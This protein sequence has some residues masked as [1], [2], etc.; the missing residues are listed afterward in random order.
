M[1]NKLLVFFL[2]LIGQPLFAKMEFLPADVMGRAAE[3]Q[4]EI[5]KIAPWA[6]SNNLT[7]LT[8]QNALV[9]QLNAAFPNFPELAE[10][11]PGPFTFSIYKRNETTISTPAPDAGLFAAIAQSFA[12][13]D[14]LEEIERTFERGDQEAI[15]KLLRHKLVKHIEDG[16]DLAQG[17]LIGIANS[18]QEDVRTKIFQAGGPAHQLD[19]L[20]NSEVDEKKLV[21][22]FNPTR[23]RVAHIPVTLTAL[24]HAIEKS[25]SLQVDFLAD[26]ILLAAFLQDDATSATLQQVQSDLVV[27]N[28]R[29]FGFLASDSDLHFRRILENLQTEELNRKANLIR[30]N[31]EADHFQVVTREVDS[32]EKAMTIYEVQ[33]Y[34]GI[35]RGCLGGDCATNASWAFSYSPYEH[36]FY[37]YIGNKPTGYIS[38]TRLETEMGPTLYVKDIVGKLLS[39][40]M[41]E[42][43]VNVLPQIADFYGVKGISLAHSNFT[44]A[45]NKY[46]EINQ[47]L[48]RYDD[49]REDFSDEDLL[50][51]QF[52][53]N[54][55][56]EMIVNKTGVQSKYD[57]PWVHQLSV[58]FRVN[59]EIA[60]GLKLEVRDGTLEMF[61]PASDKEALLM[62]L[63]QLSIDPSSNIEHLQ[64]INMAEALYIFEQLKNPK[65][66][67][68]EPYYAMIATLFEPFG[69]E[70]SKNFI[71]THQE[72]FWQGHLQASNAFGNLVDGLV[73]DD[74]I[75]YLIAVL[76]RGY[77]I[78]WL[79]KVVAKWN[80]EI[81]DIDSFRDLMGTM[82]Q[83]RSDRDF[84]II[85][86]LRSYNS[87]LA[88]EAF[89]SEEFRERRELLLL[90]MIQK[91]VG[92]EY[93]S[94]FFESVKDSLAVASTEGKGLG[95]K[96]MATALADLREKFGLED[97]INNLDLQDWF[98]RHTVYVTTRIHKVDEIRSVLQAVAKYNH[99]S[100]ESL[101][102]FV[103]INQVWQYPEIGQS[104]NAIFEKNLE[105]KDLFFAHLA[106][107][108]AG[109]LESLK[110]IVEHNHIII[111]ML[112]NYFRATQSRPTHQ[113][114][115]AI[116][117]FGNHVRG[118]LT[119]VWNTLNSYYDGEES[120]VLRTLGL[121][122]T[123]LSSVPSVA[124][125]IIKQRF[126]SGNI[127]TTD[128][129]QN[130]SYADFFYKYMVKL[131]DEYNS[132]SLYLVSRALEDSLV[133]DNNLPYR[134]EL[135]EKYRRRLASLVKEE[136][137]W[138]LNSVNVL[139]AKSLY[140]PDDFV[141]SPS[142]ISRCLA[143]ATVVWPKPREERWHYGNRID[144][145]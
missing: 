71:N 32:S 80:A 37:I 73:P 104:Y 91:G 72:F 39:P 22:K 38:A 131:I 110:Y 58:R 126:L 3:I 31:L 74:T 69:I 145:N 35:H 11:K 49:R 13:R 63:G 78:E 111:E 103:L 46:L 29:L 133:N 19:V 60:N 18:Q 41:V 128:L 114:F 102:D 28:P 94:Q 44:A 81:H 129:N 99:V 96:K 62:A 55:I 7:Y 92:P 30:K 144:S 10:A 27:N 15:L 2:I 122:Y 142:L 85:T 141:L 57:S 40:H 64:G 137:P 14:V 101:M 4:A 53:D 83:R 134:N 67:K 36:V 97:R 118:E 8:Q 9:N 12:K 119:Q 65:A 95:Y 77:D 24:I 75:R 50:H 70:L 47:A 26:L 117:P 84:A 59:A 56:R 107:H 33:P 93:T 6:R 143:T 79:G 61:S 100:M 112:D 21:E 88:I 115:V 17:I 113:D 116:P 54:D 120:P 42:T 123:D 48:R 106:Q 121:K 43:I 139:I 82:R 1:K 124:D 135:L 130:Q 25:L 109:N 125:Y 23:A 86:L 51:N 16:A 76:K 136:V 108:H 98:L 140:N 52:L 89:N 132:D 66:L 138:A 34:L 68:L 127:F 5:S 45:Q 90:E 105:P 20:R 87:S